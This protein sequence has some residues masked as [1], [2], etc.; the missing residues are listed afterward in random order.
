MKIKEF[1]KGFKKGQKEFGENIAIIINSVLLSLVYIL[2]VGPTFIFSKIF[3]KDFLDLDIEISRNSY[4]E[5]LNLNKKD[6]EEYYR[7]F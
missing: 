4:W 7:Q 2:G 6:I 5:E 1:F 3:G